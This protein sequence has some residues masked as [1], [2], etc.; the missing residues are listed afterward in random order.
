[1]GFVMIWNKESGV[2]AQSALL[3]SKWCM[4]H[5]PGAFMYLSMHGVLQ[6]LNYDAAAA[7]QLEETRRNKVAAVRKAKEEVER[8]ASQVTSAEFLYRDPERNWD[9]SR[10]KG[11]SWQAAGYVSSSECN[12]YMYIDRGRAALEWCF[13][14]HCNH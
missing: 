12:P 1:M 4:A 7:E 3:M 9:H 10:V 6:S 2:S 11:V 13:M 8:L 14:C 5:Q